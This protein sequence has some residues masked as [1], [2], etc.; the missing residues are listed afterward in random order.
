MTTEQFLAGIGLGILLWGGLPF[1]FWFYLDMRDR[2][3]RLKKIYASIVLVFGIASM[4]MM[5]YCLNDKYPSERRL[6]VLYMMIGMLSFLQSVVIFSKIR[7]QNFEALKRDY[8]EQIYELSLSVSKLV[9]LNRNIEKQRWKD[10]YLNEFYRA[11]LDEQIFDTH[12]NYFRH[13]SARIVK[14]FGF[15]DGVYVSKEKNFQLYESVDEL[16]YKMPLILGWESQEREQEKEYLCKR[17]L[18]YIRQNLR[19]DKYENRKVWDKFHNHMELYEKENLVENVFPEEDAFVFTGRHYLRSL[20]RVDEK[21]RNKSVLNSNFIFYE[22]VFSESNN[23]VYDIYGFDYAKPM[24]LKTGSKK[25]YSESDLYEPVLR[26]LFI[27]PSTESYFCFIRKDVDGGYS[28]WHIDS[29]SFYDKETEEIAN[30]I[31]KLRHIW[32]PYKFSSY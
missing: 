4:L 13:P 28:V 12:K 1:A 29:A 6:S 14:T 30:E 24:N 10:S 3:D 20:S 19:C 26:E 8:K 25:M 17:I 11:Y 31:N 18:D 2:T 32:C 22:N 15:W 5:I 9:Q 21:Y 27:I 16:F 7:T 23:L